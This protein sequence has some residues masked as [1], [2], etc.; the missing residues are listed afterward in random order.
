ME[1]QG[2]K[3][4]QTR[5]SPIQISLLGPLFLEG[6]AEV[7]LAAEEPTGAPKLRACLDDLDLC[8]PT[9]PS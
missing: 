1:E 3:T 8:D 2:R 7:R 9:L 5:G 6:R 4:K